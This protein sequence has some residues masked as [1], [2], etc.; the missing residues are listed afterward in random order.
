MT[1][2]DLKTGMIL[3]HR[4]GKLSMVLRGTKDGDIL[5]SNDIYGNYFTSGDDIF[6]LGWHADNH[7]DDVVGVWQ[8]N[9]SFSYLANGRLSV[10]DCKIIWERKETHTMTID[11]TDV[12]ISDESYKN[13]KKALK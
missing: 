1:R 6:S 13:L 9:A 10:R 7:H 11:G 3:E 12:E 2:K 8:P 4:D 5:A